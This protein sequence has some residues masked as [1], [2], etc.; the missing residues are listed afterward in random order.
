MPVQIPVQPVA[1]T[2]CLTASETLPFYDMV[3]VPQPNEVANHQNANH[4]LD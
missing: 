1:H 2:T 4:S 3:F